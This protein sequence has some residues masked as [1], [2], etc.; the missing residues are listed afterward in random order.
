MSSPLDFF[1]TARPNSRSRP[2]QTLGF[3]GTVIMAG[4]VQNREKN[5]AV[6]G[7]KRWATYTDILLNVDIVGASVRYYLNMGSRAKWKVDPADDSEAALEIAEFVF[8]ELMGMKEPTWH[9][10]V[11]RALMYRYWGFSI[12][13]W[14]AGRR[15]DGRLGFDEVAARPQ[16]TIYRWATDENGRVTDVLQRVFETGEE[17]LLPR[18]KLVY[19]VDDALSDSPEG[20]GLF[21]QMVE[22]AYRLQRYQE[23][24]AFGFEKDLRGIPKGRAPIAELNAQVRAKKLTEVQKAKILE[25]L[26]KFVKSYIRNPEAGITLDSTTYRDR[27]ENE[28]PSSQYLW[29]L[30]LITG[31]NT[32]AEAIAR[33]IERLQRELARLSGTEGILLGDNRVGSLALAENKSATF[34]LVID[35]A[36]TDIQDA[37]QV[38]LVETLMILN[39]IPEDLWPTLKPEKVQFRTAAE[40]A[41]VLEVLARAGAPLA[42]DDPAIDEVREL[43]GLSPQPEPDDLDASLRGGAPTP[44]EPPP[45]DDPVQDL[46]DQAAGE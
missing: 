21:R 42:V 43:A 45:D 13:E 41:D 12:Q 34:A 36:L 20:V 2:T 32:S 15:D 26:T 4:M 27:G 38:D 7:M 18:E 31:G 30:E 25:P 10:V 5:P 39:G 17:A 24:E 33:S 14:T 11:R 19:L 35:S 1:T 23:L 29:D 22:T 37:F 44:P 16:P 3:T 28:S 6:V 40:L 46:L 9:R 8:E